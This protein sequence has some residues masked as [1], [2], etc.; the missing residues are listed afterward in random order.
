MTKNIEFRAWQKITRENPFRATIT[1]KIDGTNG[2]IIINDGKLAGV[3]SKNRV[4]TIKDDNFG[5]AQWALDNAEDLAALGDGYHYGEW[6]GPGIQ[7]NNHAL[8]ERTFFL[9]NT[10]RWQEQRPACCSVVPVLFD[11]FIGIDTI[12]E[13]LERLVYKDIAIDGYKPE[14][15]VVYYHA[16]RR[17]TKHTLSSPNG[18]WCK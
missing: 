5:F 1:E 4:I 9:F 8:A 14:G 16:F 15:I 11:G 6:A 3:Q 10:H 13:T 18:K 2:C 12:K 7:H 17:Y